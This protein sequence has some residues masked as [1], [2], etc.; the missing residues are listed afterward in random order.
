MLLPNLE[1]N[2]LWLKAKTPSTGRYT[3]TY[4]KTLSC[5][6]DPP[7]ATTGVGPCSYIANGLVL[8][9]PVLNATILAAENAGLCLRE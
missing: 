8:R 2:D 4:L 5:P 9:D 6:S 7:P 3:G 1:R